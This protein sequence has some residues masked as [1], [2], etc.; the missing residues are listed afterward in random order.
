MVALVGAGAGTAH[1]GKGVNLKVLSNRADLISAGDA[2]V[3]VKLGKRVDPADVVVKDGRRNVTNAF[4]VGAD[5]RFIGLVEGLDVGRNVLRARVRGARRKRD[6]QVIRNHPNGGP[7]FSGPLV[8]PWVCQE[9]AVDEQ[10]NEPPAYEFEYMPEGGGG[11]QPYDP[12]DPP[13][14]VATTTTDEGNE[15]PFIVRIETGYQLRDQYKIAVLYD[16]EKPFTATSPQDGFNHKL[17]ITHGASCGIEREAGEAPSVTSDTVVGSSPEVAL[18]RGFAVMSTAL[19]NAGHNCNIITQAE[20]LVMAKER[21]V[22]RYG[23][24]RYTIGTGCSGGSLTQQQ[25]ANAYP[26]IYQGI[27][28]ACSFPDAWSTGQQLAA[29]NLLR[30]YLED[31]SKWAP[32]VS[33]DPAS[34]GAVEGHPNHVNSIVF[35]SVYWTDLGVPDDGCA[36]V[37]DDQVYNAESNPGGVRCTLADYMI[38][39]FGPRPEELWSAP[40]K[41]IGRGFAGLPLGDEGVQFGLKALERGQITPAQFVDL[42]A[43]VGGVDIDIQW[44]PQRIAATEPAL[45]NAYRSGAVNQGNNLDK[46][47]IIDLRGPDPGAFH[48]AYRSWATRARLEREQGHFKNHVIWLGHVPLFG[49]PEYMTDGLLAMDRWLAAV[50]KDSSRRPLADKIVANRPE[51]IQDKCSQFPGVEAVVVPGIGRVC[52]H[53]QVETRYGTPATVAGESVATDTNKCQLKPLRRTDYYPIEFTDE[54]WAQLEATFPTGVCDWSRPGVS[55]QDTIPWQTYQE[56]ATGERVIY[57]GRPLGR[58][59]SGS[60][61]GWTSRSF[62]GWRRAVVG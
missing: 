10:C 58:A 59:P 19:D 61:G 44:T 29:Y 51:N 26:G 32:G 62:R 7:V 24:L 2:L 54:Q 47:A 49:D 21:L 57:G 55:Q 12:E 43:K 16:P 45:T 27:L 35:D 37:S 42:N 14:D 30:R 9:T 23:E 3:E 50:E 15:V 60:G 52:E 41:A 46:V 25:V 6:R 13:S 38:N 34:I 22:E 31:P 40:E 36:G 33:W 39:V 48:D 28:P 5:G 8:Q 1:A 18:G 56:D 4:S 20:S 53:D 11:F 17:L